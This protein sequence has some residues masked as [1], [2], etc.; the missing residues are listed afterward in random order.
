MKEALRRAI[1]SG[2]VS[3][4]FWAAVAPD[5]AAC[6]CGS[7]TVCTAASTAEAIFVGRATGFTSGVQFEVERAFLGVRPGK[8]TLENTPSNCA[9]RV[10]LGE[11]YLV[12]AYRERPAG[13]LTLSMCTRTRPLSDPLARADVAYLTHRRL[14][15]G[16][17]LMTGVITDVT[18]DLATPGAMQRP[19]AGVRVTATPLDGG[20]SRTV[21]TDADGRYEL[22]K[23][24]AGRFN[25][26]ASLPPQFE[27]LEPVTV[28]IDERRGCA[29]ANIG[30]RID[31]RISG[32][33]LDE[34]G[35]PMRRVV[36]QLA[37]PAQARALKSP[38]RT[39][40]TI[41]T[42]Q[43]QFEFRYVGPGRYVVG[44]NLH[45]PL[46]SGTLNRR[47]FYG[48]SL[49]PATATVVEIETAERRVLPP[50]RLPP[51]PS[52]RLMTIVVQAP[53]NEVARATAL[54][55]TGAAREPVAQT[56]DPVPLRLP[57]GASY[58]IEA[59]P[60]PGYRIIEPANVRIQPDDTDKTIEFR[61]EKP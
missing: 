55:L 40:E 42:Y 48:E 35:Q 28:T 10:T 22:T 14:G 27:P 41:T 43:G 30:V 12:Y 36:V 49:D 4:C 18:M 45:M 57:F 39:I 9:L 26:T 60:P 17:P 2:A 61:V 13:P 31:G 20:R 24:P 58:L 44:V 32:Q 52:D 34:Q 47:R 51:L 11:R 23:V 38:L 16:R 56:G 15:S 54:F 1:V 37:D 50:F 8:I 53:T 33:L 25:I 29:E 19:V 21:T 7:P 6:D 5:A 46:R 59:V 3:L